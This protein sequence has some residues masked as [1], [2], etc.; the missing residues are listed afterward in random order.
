MLRIPIS[1]K[2]WLAFFMAIEFRFHYFYNGSFIQL[3]RAKSICLVAVDIIH[4]QD[5]VPQAF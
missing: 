1:V 3:L 5:H 4:H 2:K